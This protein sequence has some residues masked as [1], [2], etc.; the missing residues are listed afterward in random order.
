M[1]F[2]KTVTANGTQPNCTSIS[3]G[4]R[5]IDIECLGHLVT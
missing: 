4:N 3:V 1:K 2:N 5:F